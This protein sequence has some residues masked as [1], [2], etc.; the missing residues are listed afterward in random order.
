MP[1]WAKIIVAVGGIAALFLLFDMGERL[2]LFFHIVLLP[3]AFLALMG[4]ITQET[5]DMIRD[6]VPNP[7]SDLRERVTVALEEQR[8]QEEPKEV[9]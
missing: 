9:H 7:I 8:A 3:F 1:G 2:F 5:Y 4:L 6:K